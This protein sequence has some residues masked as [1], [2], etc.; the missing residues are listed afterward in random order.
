MYNLNVMNTI[1]TTI[2][3]NNLADVIEEVSN[4]KDYLFVA[5]KGK[6]TSAL[7]DID[8]FEDL[9][10]LSSKKLHNHIKKAR[11]EFKGGEIFS[12]EDIFGKL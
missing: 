10:A 11:K 7:V 2:L 6:I 3:R 4:K 5:K 9:L 8:F 12:H 1:T